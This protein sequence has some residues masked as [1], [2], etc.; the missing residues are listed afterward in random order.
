MGWKADQTRCLF[1]ISLLFSFSN[2]R[3][4]LLKT[5]APAIPNKAGFRRTKVVR[6]LAHYK[7]HT[8]TSQPW[9]PLVEM[10][11][12]CSW[13]G[14]KPHNNKSNGWVTTPWAS[15]INFGGGRWGGLSFMW[16]TKGP[17]LP[18]WA[19]VDY[20]CSGRSW[21][22]MSDFL[23]LPVL[24]CTA[25]RLFWRLFFLLTWHQFTI[26]RIYQG[27][28]SLMMKTRASVPAR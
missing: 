22:V 15:R 6:A 25:I 19:M 17:F 13:W 21:P 14:L 5:R 23:F 28:T 18:A 1:S 12:Q 27:H 2:A 3:I 8:T 11:S 24:N 10:A 4:V 7:T 9:P 26:K 16:C 20:C